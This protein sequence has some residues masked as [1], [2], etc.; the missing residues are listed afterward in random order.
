MKTRTHKRWSLALVAALALAACGGG[1]NGGID[2][3]GG[4]GNGGIDGTGVSY[5]TITG[6]GSVWVNGVKFETTGTTIK[7]DDNTVGQDDLR[8]GMVVRVNGSIDNRSAVSITVDDAIKGRVEQVIDA[9]QMVVMGQT[10]QIDNQTRFDNGVVPVAGDYVEVH[11]LPVAD[12][13]I[14]GSYIEKKTTLATPPYAVKGFVKNH[15]TAARTFV[16]GTLNVSY[17][18][19]TVNDMGSGLWNGRVV[20]VKGSTCA[21]N[22]VCGTLTASKVE[23]TGASVVSAPKAEF[24]GF[25]TALGAN[26]FTLGATPVVTTASTV[27]EG[28]VAAEIVVGTKLE[29]EGRI[30]NG[31]LTAVKVS[32]RDNVELEGNVVSF[33]TVTNSVTLAGLPNV[34]VQVT[35]LTRFEEVA[36][37]EEVALGNHVRIKARPGPGAAVLAIEFELKSMAGDP[38]VILQGPVAAIGGTTTLT[39]QGTTVDTA[40]V[41]DNEF[42]GFDDLV[43][44]RAAFFAG[45]QVGTLVKVRGELGAGDTVRWNQAELED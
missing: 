29:V 36:S 5:G 19:A 31:V 25:V 42:K 4:G 37:L 30:D 45:L 8:L 28:G 43:L 17:A 9:S 11:G 20:E 2:G 7:L 35:S 10:V 13:V 23:P 32:F 15:D 6:F 38:R 27:F 40:T 44:G 34:P 24:E 33:D 12:G 41:A 22:P 16:V 26:G 21:G 3:T 1:D 39:I 14:A 18:G